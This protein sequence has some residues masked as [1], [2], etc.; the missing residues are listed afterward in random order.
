MGVDTK[1]RL[2][3]RL[4]EGKTYSIFMSY[5]GV[6]EKSREVVLYCG[7]EDHKFLFLKEGMMLK[8]ERVTR[9]EFLDRDRYG[10]SFRYII[11]ELD[12]TEMAKKSYG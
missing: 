2:G 7:R 12:E 8:L 4:I 11:G 6:D 10:V 9:Q 3:K 1:N 5:F